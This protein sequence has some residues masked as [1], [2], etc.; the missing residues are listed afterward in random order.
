M[1][2]LALK[3]ENRRSFRYDPIQSSIYLGW[4]EEPGFRTLAG[5]LKNLSH[6]G[7]LVLAPEPPPE[8]ERLW[9]CM[10][11]I[12]G[13]D[14]AEVVVVS[15]T[16]RSPTSHEVRVR[17]VEICPYELFTLAVHGISVGL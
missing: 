16:L 2:E 6:G 7:A 3:R 11:G 14:W 5:E 15:M 12:P 4:W 8:G 1:V 9:L 10:T 13:G 17:F